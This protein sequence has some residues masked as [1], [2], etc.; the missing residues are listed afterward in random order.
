M[1]AQTTQPG[2]RT[3][4]WGAEAVTAFFFW[5]SK[6]FGWYLEPSYGVALGDGN[7]KSAALTAGMFFA[8]P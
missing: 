7:K 2:L 5:R 6:R 4:S 1:W 3:G 8:V